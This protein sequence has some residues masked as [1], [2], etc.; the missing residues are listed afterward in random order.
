MAKPWNEPIMV[1]FDLPRN[2]EDLKDSLW[3]GKRKFR[4]CETGFLWVKPAQ[5]S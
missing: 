5:S 1:R 3:E 2:A 4:E